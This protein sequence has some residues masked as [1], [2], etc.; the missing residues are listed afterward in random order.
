MVQGQLFEVPGWPA[1]AHGAPGGG[2]RDC[3][4]PHEKITERIGSCYVVHQLFFGLTYRVQV[5][6]R[7]ITVTA[8]TFRYFSRT[9][10]RDNDMRISQQVLLPRFDQ[11]PSRRSLSGVTTHDEKKKHERARRRSLLYLPA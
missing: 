10:F 8:E 6:T 2:L 9:I 3:W 11:A 1:C 7:F 4:E 5:V